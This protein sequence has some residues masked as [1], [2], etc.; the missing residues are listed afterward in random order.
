M[1]PVGV[2]KKINFRM[3]EPRFIFYYDYECPLCIKTVVFFKHFDVFGA[4][5]FKTV[6]GN[7][8][9]DP[10]IRDIPEE[11][12]LLDIYSV[13]LKRKKVYSGYESYAQLF[14]RMGYT[15]IIG[16]LMK[17]PV[18]NTIGKSIYK[19]V[20]AGRGVY[21][22]THETCAVPVF[23]EPVKDHEPLLVSWLSKD[24]MTRKGWKYFIIILLVF[25]VVC[26][27]FSAYPSNLRKKIPGY[28]AEK[29]SRFFQMTKPFRDFGK[30]YFG[31]T[32]HPVFMDSHFKGYNHIFRVTYLDKGKEITLPVINDNGM[33]G[34]YIRGAFWVNYTFRVSA[35]AFNVEQY[36]RGIRP[37]LLYWLYHK[38]KGLTKSHHFNVYVKE[39]EIPEDWEKD[40]LNKQL[41]KPWKPCGSI[42]LNNGELS[43]TIDP[44]IH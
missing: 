4:I 42:D 44:S 34:E 16:Y 6:Q 5:S 39:V 36:N 21:R 30:N 14:I 29:E 12:L 19:K 1:V 32:N 24:S 33:P 7:Y 11:R 13:D 23:N 40:F 38:G 15:F 8:S 2:W 35:P 25:Q 10:F 26:S 9:S 20:A 17:L 27:L 28:T 3:K 37:Y 18:L 31:I 43:S 22:C 41:A